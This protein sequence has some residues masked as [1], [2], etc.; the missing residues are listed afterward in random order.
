MVVGFLPRLAWGQRRYNASWFDI[1][2]H[3][4]SEH[5]PWPESVAAQ[6]EPSGPC[7]FIHSKGLSLLSAKP[8]NQAFF[9]TFH[10]SYLMQ[11]FRIC[12]S[13]GAVQLPFEYYKRKFWILIHQPSLLTWKREP[14]PVFSICYLHWRFWRAVI[15]RSSY[16]SIWSPRKTASLHENPWNNH[17][18]LHSHTHLGG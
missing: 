14:A 12:S 2:E 5:Q 1:L 13:S 4:G 3:P 16:V 11:K 18:Q 6:Y 15:W 9:H 7:T 10:H 17:L 8:I